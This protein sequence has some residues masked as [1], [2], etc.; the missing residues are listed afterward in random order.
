M[1]LN[2]T[3]EL[4]AEIDSAEPRIVAHSG[5]G[6]ASA[7]RAKS[8]RTACGSPPRGHLPD[9]TTA[10]D[11]R[12]EWL[13]IAAALGVVHAIFQRGWLCG[14]VGAEA[15]PIEAFMPVII[16]ALAS[17]HASISNSR[18][19]TLRALLDPRTHSP[20][21]T[22]PSRARSLRRLVD[23]KVKRQPLKEKAREEFVLWPR[24]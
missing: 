23:G 7:V 9:A 2:A 22:A 10:T 19:N 5:S 20:Q 6:G 17:N 11:K 15:A 18:K 4:T 3:G 12:I 13:P 14:L 24:S 1:S 21:G 8:C 16:F